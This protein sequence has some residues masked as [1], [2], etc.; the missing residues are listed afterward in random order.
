MTD[1]TS[2]EDLDLASRMG[3]RN[4]LALATNRLHA[5]VLEFPHGGKTREM[6]SR[7]HEEAH[8]ALILH[9]HVADLNK[10]QRAMLDKAKRD[11]GLTVKKHTR[12][13]KIA[14]Q[15]DRA[16]LIK[17]VYYAQNWVAY[18]ITAKGRAHP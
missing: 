16:G 15:L 14:D 8:E 7:W 12:A 17:D 5:L 6:V 3:L 2:Q 13:S 18:K 9:G 10:G 4:A 11:S 1:E